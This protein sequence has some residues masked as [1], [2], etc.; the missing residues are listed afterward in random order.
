MIL[1]APQMTW[2]RLMGL[3][4]TDGCFYVSVRKDGSLNIAIILTIGRKNVY[5]TDQVKIFL[6]KE[7]FLP[8]I[9]IFDSSGTLLQSASNPSLPPQE[10]TLGELLEKKATQDRGSNITIRGL[11]NCKQLVNKM[12]KEIQKSNGLVTFFGP[13]LVDFLVF[14]NL[15]EIVI[16]VQKGKRNEQ[17]AKA[18]YVNIIHGFR[19]R[20]K[21]AVTLTS[22]ELCRRLQL[23]S[24][25]YAYDPNSVIWT[26]AA[27]DA[28]NSYKE[29]ANKC[30]QIKDQNKPIPDPLAEFIVGVYDGDGSYQVG[31]HI[32][33]KEGQDKDGNKTYTLVKRSDGSTRAAYDIVPMLT[34][35]DKLEYENTRFNELFNICAILLNETHLRKTKKNPNVGEKS[36]LEMESP[37][38]KPGENSNRFQLRDT[39]M[40]QKVV[41]PL[42]EKNP[43]FTDEQRQRFHVLSEIAKEK[44]FKT[45]QAALDALELLYNNQQVFKDDVRKNKKETMV[46]LVKMTFANKKR[47]GRP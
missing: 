43:P 7:G 17:S 35:T 26:K 24:T 29:A 19:V 44:P 22:Q 6:T 1:P 8:E 47:R 36:V 25:D 42:F 11:E 39:K 12:N 46:Q 14:S 21:N 20:R 31:T 16:E 15:L 38:Y 28:Q 37:G 5:L 3:Y 33:A 18:D 23:P 10:D 9:Q 40:L 27:T 30:I 4:Q 41:I 34:L 13:K 32:L 2:P 45:E